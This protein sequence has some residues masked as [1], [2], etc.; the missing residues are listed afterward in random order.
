MNTLKEHIIHQL[1]E[2]YGGDQWVT[3][4]FEKK[5]AVLEAEAALKRIPGFN[6]N[7]AEIVE[8]MAA[9]RYFGFR[10]LQGDIEFDIVDNTAADWPE[11]ETW[12]LTLNNF[13]QSQCSLIKALNEFPAERLGDN[14]PRRSYDFAYLINGILQ[15]DYYHYGQIG[16][17]IA[18]Q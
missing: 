13:Y 18:A 11:A 5:V 15:H 1:N 7:I 6:H 14:V 16:C 10:K 17:L 4:N 12:D 3:E 2:F 8:H 9:W